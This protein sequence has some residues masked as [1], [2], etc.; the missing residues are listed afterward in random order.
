MEA[1]TEQEQKKVIKFG[2]SARQHEALTLLRSNDVT[3][4]YFGGA[5]GGGKTMLGCYWQI[6]NRLRYP[7][8]RGLIGRNVLKNLLESTYITWK[9]VADMLGLQPGID[10]SYNAQRNRTTFKNG[11]VIVWKELMYRPRDQDFHS[12]G[13]TEY[14]DAFID[15][16]H[17]ITEKAFDTINSRLRWKVT[18]F[19]LTPKILCTGNP[20]HTWVRGKYIKNTANQ[21]IDLEP[22][23][24]RVLSKVTDNPDADFVR[25]YSQ[26]LAKLSEYDR[27]RLLDGDWDALPR[28]GH[29]YYHEYTDEQHRGVTE[30][31]KNEALHWM[32]DFNTNPYIT[33]LSFHILDRVD[34]WE[35]AG[36]KEFCLPHPKNSPRAVTETA[37]EFY[38][39]HKMPIFLYGD[40]TIWGQQKM[41]L[42]Y[43]GEI[44]D[45]HYDVMKAIMMSNGFN[46]FDR[47]IPNKPVLKR[48]GFIK[49]ILTNKLP[50]RL[51]LH[52]DMVQT[53]N[54]F[55]YMKEGADS[56][57]LKEMVTD[58]KTRIK[59][60]K[61][62]HPTDAFEYFATSAFEPDYEAYFQMIANAQAS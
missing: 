51:K 24:R 35:L 53:I 47:V 41:G 12:L 13:S 3:E 11:S 55:R 14:T 60:Q 26:Q 43:R 23:Q 48:K 54:D 50:F 39:G 45:Y 16:V 7:G 4:V 17:E 56:K 44:Y 29:E 58:E 40:Y 19:G 6:T 5:A 52:P 49:A 37:C 57:K 21:W 46:V 10:Y 1:A 38:A 8:S 32:V 9:K 33:L 22:Y 62:G 20:A 61:H 28:T 42:E 15:E 18:D 30:Y 59:Y 36:L 34:Y 2:L 25:V 27:L 31:D